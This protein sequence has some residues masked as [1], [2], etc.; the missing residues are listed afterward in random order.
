MDRADAIGLQ[1]AIA[2]A[3]KSYNDGGVPIGAALVYHGEPD[4]QGKSQP[5][6]LGQGHN[7]R[8]QK[9]SPILHGETSA[10]K[11]AGRLK[12]E[13]YRN[14]TMYTTLSPCSMCS[15]A[16]M[17]YKIPRLVIGENVNFK[18]D[19]DLLRSRGV[20]VI[21]LDNAECKELMRKFIAEK[22]EEWYEDIGEIPP[23]SK[24]E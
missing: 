16:V 4:A 10:L 9:E 24:S 22:P 17:L 13:I 3:R 14:S 11:D 23:P 2:H 19:E 7:Q 20:E 5:K 21:V 1:A 18:G 8:I 15:G 12:A 6:L